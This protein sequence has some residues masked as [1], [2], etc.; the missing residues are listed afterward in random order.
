LDSLHLVDPAILPVLDLIPALDLTPD[1]LAAARAGLSLM[2][3]LPDNGVSVETVSIPGLDG[4]PELDLIVYRPTATT[5]V[6]PCIYHIHG[7]GFVLGS[8]A[9]FE[10]LCRPLAAELNCVIVSVDY[11]LAPE[12]IAPGAVE[13]CYAGLAWVFANA[14]AR[15]IDPARIGVMGESAGGGHAAALALMARDRMAQGGGD[16]PLAFQHLIY[17]MLDDRTAIAEPHPF[18]GEFVWTASTNHFGWKSLL[19]HEPGIGGVSE[20]TAAARATDLSNLPPT[21]ISV[22]ALDIFIDE[23]LEYARRL[24][25]AGVPTELHVYPGAFHGFDMMRG[26]PIADAA[27]GNSVAALKRFIA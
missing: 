26:A 17:P 22:G 4:A 19:G 1:G 15:D 18:A 24:I 8:A 2:P 10:S 9:N 20:Y 21:F 16:Y 14:E 12:T 5:G 23:D 11:R 13:D 25:R 27:H 6:L 7:G 3:P